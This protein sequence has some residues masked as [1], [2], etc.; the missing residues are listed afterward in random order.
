[1]ETQEQGR[2]KGSGLPRRVLR[3]GRPLVMQSSAGGN[4]PFLTGVVEPLPHVSLGA[5]GGFTVHRVEHRSAVDIRDP[6]RRRTVTRPFII[7]ANIAALISMRQAVP[8]PVIRLVP[9]QLPD[10]LRA[11]GV[12]RDVDELDVGHHRKILER[13]ASHR[14][15]KRGVM[16]PA[17]HEP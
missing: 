13:L 7:S 16:R 5:V 17:G 12:G 15:C 3:R 1:M 14:S 11:C 10:E 9:A 6:V 2:P 4:A 8:K